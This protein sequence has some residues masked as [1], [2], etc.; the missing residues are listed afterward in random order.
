MLKAYVWAKDTLRNLHLREEAQDGFE[1]LLVVGGVSVALV[2]AMLVLA[3]DTAPGVVGTV[4]G[5]IAGVLTP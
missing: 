2:V 1:Y 5:L 4:Q 3:S